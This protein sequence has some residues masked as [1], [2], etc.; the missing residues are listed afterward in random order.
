MTKLLAVTPDSTNY[1]PFYK[2]TVARSFDHAKALIQQAEEDG[3]PFDTLDL[4]VYDED[5]FWQFLNWMR[6]T[7]R[8]YSFSVFGY[9]NTFHFWNLCNKARNQG[10]HFNT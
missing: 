6:S 8:N 7:G 9:R 10:F 2:V 1:A 5:I 3:A 4:P